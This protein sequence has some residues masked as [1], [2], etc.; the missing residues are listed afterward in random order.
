MADRRHRLNDHMRAAINRRANEDDCARLATALVMIDEYEALNM[1]YDE[2]QYRN[3]MALPKVQRV[4]SLPDRGHYKEFMNMKVCLELLY[5]AAHLQ[6]PEDRHNWMIQ[7]ACVHRWFYSTFEFRRMNLVPP[8]SDDERSHYRIRLMAYLRSQVWSMTNT[9]EIYD[10]AEFEVITST[11]RFNFNEPTASTIIRLDESDRTRCLEEELVRLGQVVQRSLGDA[12][13]AWKDDDCDRL[14]GGLMCMRAHMT[15]VPK[16]MYMK[17]LQEYEPVFN[18]EPGITKDVDMIHNAFKCYHELKEARQRDEI[19]VSFARCQVMTKKFIEH[20]SFRE[21]GVLESACDYSNY[22]L[23]DFR[24]KVNVLMGGA[25]SSAR[26]LR[27]YFKDLPAAAL[28]PEPAIAPDPAQAYESSSES[29]LLI[30]QQ[31]EQPQPVV[32]GEFECIFNGIRFAISRQ[33]LEHYYNDNV[34]FTGQRWNILTAWLEN[35]FEDV[36]SEV[37]DRGSF[38]T[39]VQELEDGEEDESTTTPGTLTTGTQQNDI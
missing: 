5:D 3:F 23:D 37:I 24:Q 34:P 32:P 30:A 27:F 25:A 1:A 4:R 36:F 20:F 13:G 21:A 16:P 28:E 39:H 6:T 11:E 9:R 26:R 38:D 17:I 22:L 18:H 29:E 19:M 15:G 14:V 31:P 7:S 35:H 2:E 12:L 10:Q 8:P 33:V